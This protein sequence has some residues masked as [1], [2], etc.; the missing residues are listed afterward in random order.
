MICSCLIPSRGRFDQLLRTVTS[1][2]KACDNPDEVEIVIRMDDC[3]KASMSR[4]D[5][6]LFFGCKV[7]VGPRLGGYTSLDRFCQELNDAAT[8]DW[9]WHL[10][11]D[12][13]I[14]REAGHAGFDTLLKEIQSPDAICHTQ[15]HLLGKSRYERDAGGPAPI[16]RRAMYNDG[17][18][19]GM[20]PDTFINRD[21][22]KRNYRTFFLTGIT[23]WHDWHGH[24]ENGEVV[25]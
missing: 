15:W 9:C 1:I 19:I 11:N 14:Q 12:M 10:S 20:P 13:V 25:K 16:Y 21:A 24:E 6:L 3:D 4:K 7:M 5:E 22:K 2:F 17:K 23:L 8:G 18:K